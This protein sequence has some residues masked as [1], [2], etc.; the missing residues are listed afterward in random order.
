MNSITQ[1]KRF[2]EKLSENQYQWGEPNKEDYFNE[3][4]SEFN[5]THN[6]E[7]RLWFS[8]NTMTVYLDARRKN[9][10]NDKWIMIASKYLVGSIFEP[11][12]RKYVNLKNL[13]EKNRNELKD[14]VPEIEQYFRGE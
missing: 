10:R 7:L 8:L 12:P 11:K 14:F 1:I 2:V 4:I 5:K 6:V 9:A 3:K 13:T